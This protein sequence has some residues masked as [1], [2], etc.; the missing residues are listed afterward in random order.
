MKYA[1]ITIISAILIFM[2]T[3]SKGKLVYNGLSSVSRV[4]YS[5]EK[6]PTHPIGALALGREMGPHKSIETL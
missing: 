2:A 3:N 6:F 5:A 1:F 4:S